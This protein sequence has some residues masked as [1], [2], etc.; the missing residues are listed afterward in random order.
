MDK[1]KGTDS[2]IDVQEDLELAIYFGRK[3]GLR[4]YSLSALPP[5]GV[6]TL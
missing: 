4:E 5:L 6:A 1:Q 2:G 3:A